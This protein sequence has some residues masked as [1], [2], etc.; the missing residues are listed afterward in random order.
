MGS[1][2]QLAKSLPQLETL[3]DH[4]RVLCGLGVWAVA[5]FNLAL[6][7][8]GGKAPSV[9]LPD[10]I[11]MAP[12]T[13]TCLLLVGTSL[14]VMSRAATVGWWSGLGIGCAGAVAVISTLRLLGWLTG[15][16]MVIDLES[17]TT[18]PWWV[19]LAGSGSMVPLAAPGAGDHEHGISLH[20]DHPP[21]AD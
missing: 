12:I 2:I 5:A 21:V 4:L 11:T 3:T 17:M 18:L 6:W 15:N 13:A 16:E 10:E 8:I 20:D 14:L 9:L 1:W 19:R 7:I